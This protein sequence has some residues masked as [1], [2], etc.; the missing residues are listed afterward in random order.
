[1]IKATIS[2]RFMPRPPAMMCLF[3]PNR[4]LL[5]PQLFTRV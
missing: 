2:V 3:V 1:M 5:R 4:L